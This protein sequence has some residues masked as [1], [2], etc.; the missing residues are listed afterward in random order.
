MHQADVDLTAYVKCQN[1]H[2]YRNPIDIKDNDFT[3]L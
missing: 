2:D 3:K 1:S